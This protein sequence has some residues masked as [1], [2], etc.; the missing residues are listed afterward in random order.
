VTTWTENTNTSTDL[1]SLQELS[2]AF[3]LSYQ[4]LNYYTSLGLINAV[5]RQG[6][7][8][9]YSTIKVKDRLDKI[10]RLKN[11]GYPLRVIAN[12]LNNV[13]GQDINHELF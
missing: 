6:N 5:K 10:L 4:T 3:D 13:N 12:L 11:E 1:V 2:K 9:L 7:K 8:R